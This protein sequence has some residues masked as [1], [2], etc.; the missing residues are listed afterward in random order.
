MIDMIDKAQEKVWISV[1]TFTLPSLRASLVRAQKR[2]VD[3]RVILEKFP[4]GNT[5]INRETV[6]FL[7]GNT[8]P[9][10]QSS[11]NQFAFMH[12]KYALIDTHWIIET[13]NWTR[14]SFSSNREFFIISDDPSI[15]ES[16]SAIFE[17]DFSG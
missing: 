16:L 6:A 3:V 9:L 13:A 1:Y 4:F 11:E 12:A 10:H 2:G 5:D 8:I 15:H 7:R 14:A 17:G